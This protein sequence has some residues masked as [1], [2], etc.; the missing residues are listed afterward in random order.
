M[1]EVSFF[2]EKEKSCLVNG[3][4]KETT[5][6]DDLCRIIEKAYF[7]TKKHLCNGEFGF[8]RT[9]MEYDDVNNVTVRCFNDENN[10]IKKRTFNISEN[11]ATFK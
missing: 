11:M 9:T 4:A 7:N 6:Y 2:D 3:Y 5:K 1:T 8:A 10:E